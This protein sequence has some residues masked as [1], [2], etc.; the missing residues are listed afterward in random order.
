MVIPKVEDIG[1]SQAAIDEQGETCRFS[2]APTTTTSLSSK[3]EENLYRKSSPAANLVNT[4]KE[5]NILK[6]NEQCDAK[7]RMIKEDRYS[8]SDE[9]LHRRG[10]LSNHATAERKG[11]EV[12]QNGQCEIYRL[13]KTSTK[14]L[15]DGV[16]SSNSDDDLYGRG[17]G[18]HGNAGTKLPALL[19]MGAAESVNSSNVVKDPRSL[20]FGKNNSSPKFSGLFSNDICQVQRSRARSM[21]ASDLESR[22]HRAGWTS[23]A[24]QRR[25]NESPHFTFQNRN[26]CVIDRERSR[27]TACKNRDI[28]LLDRYRT[29]AST[30]HNPE[31]PFS[32]YGEPRARDS[33]PSSEPPGLSENESIAIKGKFRQIGHSVL[34]IA[35]MKK[36]AKKK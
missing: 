21:N 14:I 8:K 26:V 27:A 17:L 32:E 11:N 2:K 10:L 4:E 13:S 22:K 15:K 36:M 24:T 28:C 33:N 5:K 34:A 35:L 18:N 16:Y 29:R 30:V 19:S 31:S 1:E 23:P 7:P 20:E 25:Q 12:N 6:E 3:S 9:N